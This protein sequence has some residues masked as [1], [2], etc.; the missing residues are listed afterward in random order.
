MSRNRKGASASGERMEWNIAE[1][2]ETS[3]MPPVAH[4][5]PVC[6]VDQPFDSVDWTHAFRSPVSTLRSV[7]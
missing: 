5:A 6:R 7:S 2:N 3:A 4:C 1:K